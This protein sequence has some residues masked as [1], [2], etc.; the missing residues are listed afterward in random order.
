MIAEMVAS[1]VGV[2]RRLT[3]VDYMGRHEV[4]N[5]NMTNR[6]TIHS[7]KKFAIRSVQCR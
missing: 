4:K 7:K 3:D 1:I 6:L 2:E 5:W